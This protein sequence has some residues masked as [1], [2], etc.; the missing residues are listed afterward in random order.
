MLALVGGLVILTIVAVVSRALS[1]WPGHQRARLAALSASALVPLGLLVWLPS[2]PLAAGWAKRAGTPASL[3]AASTRGSGGSSST[4]PASP[5]NGGSSAG[6]SGFTAQGSGT[7]R[8]GPL[9]DGLYGVDIT[10]S[11][12]G[13]NLSALDIRLRGEQLEGGGIQMSSGEVTL[14]T[15]SNPTQY[16]GPVTGLQGSNVQA[17]VRDSSGSTLGVL[18]QLQIDTAGGQASGT[19]TATP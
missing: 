18:A 5:A 9:G 13:Q 19:V 14:G 17:R 10:L 11:L 12:S 8:Q 1:G 3:L 4:A 16:R 6:A 7:V 15:V 2:G